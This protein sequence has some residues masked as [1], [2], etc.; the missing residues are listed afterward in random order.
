MQEQIMESEKGSAYL[1]NNASWSRRASYSVACRFIRMASSSTDAA[2]ETKQS[3]IA[4]KL[5]EAVS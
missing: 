2:A 1:G 5:Y 4:D 3:N